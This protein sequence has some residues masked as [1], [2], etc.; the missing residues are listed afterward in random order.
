[1]KKDRTK[2]PGRSK[3]IV[4][5]LSGVVFIIAFSL[6]ITSIVFQ[7]DPRATLFGYRVYYISTG[8]MEPDIPQGSIVIVK[9]TPAEDIEVGD[10]ISFISSEPAIA[11][12]INTH[13]V[14][15]IERDGDGL[16]F[17][18]K[19]TA[20]DIPDEYKV[21]PDDVTGVVVKH[22]TALG[23]VF[24]TLSNRT[25]LFVL[26]IVPLA[27]IVLYSLIVLIINIYK[28]YP[29]DENAENAQGQAEFRKPKK[30]R[31][32]KT[33]NKKRGKHR[34]KSKKNE[35]SVPAYSAR[36]KRKPKWKKRNKRKY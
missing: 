7:K 20:N 33:S 31:T 18:T 9:R 26:T 35:P 19:G 3:K 24:T 21:R 25:L 1:M 2:R 8:S 11:G 34:G 17:T 23:K 10:V 14:Y 4:W 12:N 6:L 28:P 36:K 32:S 5:I 27:V 16:L 13:S 15:A 29:E 30:G 22:S